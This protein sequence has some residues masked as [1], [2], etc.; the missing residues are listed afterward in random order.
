MLDENTVEAYEDP[1]IPKGP[2]R[3]T[4][5]TRHKKRIEIASEK[6]DFLTDFVRTAPQ[7]S[8]I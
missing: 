7:A 4:K 3:T 6:V 1:F 5:Y 2:N 8:P